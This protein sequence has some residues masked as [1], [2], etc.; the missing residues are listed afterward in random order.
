MFL[1]LRV[2]FVYD[3]REREP[4]VKDYFSLDLTGMQQQRLI[5]FYYS[6]GKPVD[7]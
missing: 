7:G 4:L 1:I 5:F 3:E 6:T 2:Y